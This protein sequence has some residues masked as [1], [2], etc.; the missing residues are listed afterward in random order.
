[1]EI[2]GSEFG[3]EDPVVNTDDIGEDGGVSTIPKGRSI[4]HN[5]FDNHQA[6]FLS[7][8]IETAGEKAGIVQISAEIVCFQDQ[9]H[10]QGMLQAILLYLGHVHKGTV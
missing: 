9:F 8:D 2:L 1:M 6:V 4:A 5:T 10:W 7:F 3:C